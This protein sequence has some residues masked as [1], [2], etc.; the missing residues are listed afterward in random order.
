M[1]LPLMSSL[2]RLYPS[3]LSSMVSA[4]IPDSQECSVSPGPYKGR[5]R[6]HSSLRH[7][8]PILAL[9]LSFSIPTPAVKKMEG[10]SGLYSSFI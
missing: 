2:P 9:V 4:V 6:R 10:A 8:S 1:K 7:T 5:I 3:T